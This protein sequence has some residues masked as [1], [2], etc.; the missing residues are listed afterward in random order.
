MA[1]LITVF[2][3]DQGARTLV[4]D[5]EYANLL[6]EAAEEIRKAIRD[7]WEGFDGYVWSEHLDDIGIDD[8]YMENNDESREALVEYWRENK[9]MRQEVLSGRREDWWHDLKR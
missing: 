1:Q 6:A 7:N 2:D 9:S 5:G 4:K 3:D 8:S